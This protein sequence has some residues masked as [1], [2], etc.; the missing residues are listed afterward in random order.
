MTPNDTPVP[1]PAARAFA[2]RVALITGGGSGIGRAAA[3]AFARH[4]ARLVLG[5][6]DEAAGRQLAAESNGCIAFRRTDVTQADDIEAVMRITHESGGLDI[7]FNNA[8]AGGAREPID[9]ISAE[10]G[11]AEPSS[12]RSAFRKRVGV[13]ASAYRKKWQALMPIPS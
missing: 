13:S 11:Y 8:G 6:V 7:V 4:G 12:F 10:V 3:L 2:G 9:E 1:P 5:D